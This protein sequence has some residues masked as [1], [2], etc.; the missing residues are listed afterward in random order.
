M[1]CEYRLRAL[2]DTAFCDS[3]PLLLTYPGSS[4]AATMSLASDHNVRVSLV[5]KEGS[6][7]E[8]SSSLSA[9]YALLQF[10]GRRLPVAEYGDQ[11]TRTKS[12]SYSLR[13]YGDLSV[14]R[15]MVGQTVV[16]NDRRD[17]MVACLSNLSWNERRGFVDVS[18]SLTEVDSNEGIDYE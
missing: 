11:F 5:C 13:N 4:R 1:S 18:F 3:D 2:S 16:W 6:P 9:E 12:L 17:H 14:L 8:R 7:P 15:S 10:A